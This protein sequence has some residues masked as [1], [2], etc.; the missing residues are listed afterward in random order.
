MRLLTWNVNGLRSLIQYHPWCEHKN[1]QTLLETLDADIICFQEIKLTLDRLDSSI[2]IIHGYDAYFSF[3]KGKPAYSGVATYVKTNLITPVSA[4][5]GITGVL[6]Q[7]PADVKSPFDNHQSLSDTRICSE[8]SDLTTNELLDL[9]SEG[10]CVI[11]DFKMF[12]LF[13]LYCPHESSSERLPF[14][15][16][17]YKVL[18]ARV[19]ALLRVGRQ[20]IVLGD[21]NVTHKEIDHC[22]PQ[23]SI[24]EHEL[25][26]FDDHPARKWF[27]GF[28]APNGPMVDLFRK[29]HPDE[30]GMYTLKWFKSC[31]VE[32]KIMGSDHC[33]VVGELY[34]EI[35]ED[36]HKY[37]LRNEINLSTNINNEKSETPRL[38]AKY[39]P[40][41]NGSQRTLKSFFSK[42][43][44]KNDNS[45]SR[46][47]S[48]VIK[49]PCDNL[50]KSKNADFNIVKVGKQISK[51]SKKKSMTSKSIKFRGHKQRQKS[52]IPSNQPSLTS[53]FKQ[54]TQTELSSIIRTEEGCNSESLESSSNAD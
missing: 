35:E 20:V 13:N 25:E 37:I 33:P 26:S 21:M 38:C 40:K 51:S 54:S 48:E 7:S 47:G 5:E 9:D 52:V 53:Y 39:L 32:Q 6:N 34:D 50:P 18:Q 42:T 41:F 2:A 31:S 1:Y 12:I 14:K 29:F 36:G 27:D 28:V 24:R 30:E 16:N 43:S 15:M 19:E 45:Q 8:I 3:A 23:R 4:E 17:F 22:D 44:T 49:T 46:S 10:R 11:L